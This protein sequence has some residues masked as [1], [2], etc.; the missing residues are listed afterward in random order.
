[1]NAPIS[2]AAQLGI[3]APAIKRKKNEPEVPHG[4]AMLFGL[5][6]P[7]PLPPSSK[8][9]E[10]EEMRERCT[11]KTPR[12]NRMMN[13]KAQRALII[14]CLDCGKAT[15]ADVCAYTSLP[16]KTVLRHMEAMA[17]DGLVSSTKPGRFHVWELVEAR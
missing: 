8:Q 1:M 13:T 9:A 11:N 16:S 4:L 2:I 15:T 5:R 7:Y 14:E 3:A 12:K 10:R 17:N 6:R